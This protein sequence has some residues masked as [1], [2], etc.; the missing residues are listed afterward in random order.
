MPTGLSIAYYCTA[1]AAGRHTV[2]ID[3]PMFLPTFANAY[4]IR[5]SYKNVLVSNIMFY[6]T[7]G[8]HV[9][10]CEYEYKNTVLSMYS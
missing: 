6:F 10:Y 3:E 5:V 2:T 7:E 8:V 9:L 1:T 4:C